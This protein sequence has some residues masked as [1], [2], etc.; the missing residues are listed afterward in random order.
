MKLLIRPAAAAEI[1]RAFDWYAR[2]RPELG[3]RFLEEACAT[4]D[5]IVDRP[6]AFPVVHRDTR[7]ARVGRR[8]PYSVFFRVYGEIILVTGC[9]HARRDPRRWRLKEPTSAYSAGSG[10]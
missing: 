5:Q 6:E 1:A 3:A 10:S 7:R 9:T 8:F 2:Q 4:F